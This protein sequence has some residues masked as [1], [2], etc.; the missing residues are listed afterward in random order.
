MLNSNFIYFIQFTNGNTGKRS[1]FQARVGKVIK[2][3][4]L[5]GILIFCVKLS[6][7]LSSSTGHYVMAL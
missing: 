3:P 1:Y 6:L 7:A 5:P 2:V 4:W